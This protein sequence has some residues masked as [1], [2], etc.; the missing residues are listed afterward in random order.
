M[1][2]R[3]GSSP[4]KDAATSMHEL[5]ETLKEAGFSRRDALELISRVMTS[6]VSDAIRHS[7]DDE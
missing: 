5:Y 6:A 4:M 7:Q 2:D 1:D 3:F